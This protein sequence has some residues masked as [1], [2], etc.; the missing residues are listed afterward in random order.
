MTVPIGIG[1]GLAL[2]DTIR[3]IINGMLAAMRDGA[4]RASLR[5]LTICTNQ[6]EEHQQMYA[7]LLRFASSRTLDRLE[8]TI[9]QE[10]L[11]APPAA[12]LLRGSSL[13]ST[14]RTDYLTVREFVGPDAS[15][16]RG[17]RQ[18][19]IALLGSGQ[20]DRVDCLAGRR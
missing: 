14:F 20:G 8:L 15:Q 6:P 1:S 16:R 2:Y 4:V 3:T 17:H 5:G 19:D 12:G 13:V 10:Q 9:E 7:E 11:P 18:L